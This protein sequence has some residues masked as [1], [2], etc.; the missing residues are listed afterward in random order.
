MD[1]IKNLGVVALLIDKPEHALNRDD[2]RTT[3]SR[4]LACDSCD[5]IKIDARN[6][7][8]KPGRFDQRYEK[9]RIANRSEL[10]NYCWPRHAV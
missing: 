10:A 9:N 8:N 4:C 1:G 6:Q 2:R 5:A 7:R 3:K